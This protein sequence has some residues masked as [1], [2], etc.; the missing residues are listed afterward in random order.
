[1]ATHGGRR[2][3]FQDR[4]LNL[5][6]SGTGKESNSSSVSGIQGVPLGAALVICGREGSYSI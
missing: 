4:S 2:V 3:F 1:M 6:L 5:T